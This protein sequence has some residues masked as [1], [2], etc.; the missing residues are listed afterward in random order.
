M[1]YSAYVTF[2]VMRR[3]ENAG[4]LK[5]M[6]KDK[7]KIEIFPIT[8]D[9]LREK[10]YIDERGE[11]VLLA[12]GE[13]IRHITFFTLKPGKTFFR[14]GHYHKKKTEKF[15]V[16]SGKL[17]IHVVDVDT[18]EKDIIEI[19]AGQRVTIYPFCAHKFQAI[20]ESHVIEY[21]A[22]VYDKDDDVRFTDF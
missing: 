13:E 10:R 9:F 1:G 14:G 18:K 15:Y 5:Y 2:Y 4:Y 21:Y 19:I 8:K 3:F 7:F 16:I 6:L 11:L 22:S 12:D 20:T 17:N